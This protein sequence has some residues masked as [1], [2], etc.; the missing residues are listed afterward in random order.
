MVLKPF[1]KYNFKNSAVYCCQKLT[2]NSDSQ[3][4][5]LEMVILKNYCSVVSNSKFYKC[6]LWHLETT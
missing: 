4:V 2:G 1:T 6:V 3:N 5:I